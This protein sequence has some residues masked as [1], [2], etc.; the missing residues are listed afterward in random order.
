MK[1]KLT[2]DKIEEIVTYCEPHLN[3]MWAAQIIAILF[4]CDFRDCHQAVR[5]YRGIEE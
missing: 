4:G 3:Q 2:I 1:D 5:H